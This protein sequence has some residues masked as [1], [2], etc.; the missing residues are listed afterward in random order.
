MTFKDCEISGMLNTYG[1]AVFENCTFKSAKNQYSLHIY[2]GNNFMLTN[3]HFYG[4]DKNVYVYQETVDCEK[5]VTFNNCDFHMTAA[6]GTKSAVM[7]NSAAYV[8]SYK[9]NLVMNSCTVEG[10]N[11]TAA[12]N[13]TG[14]TNY[15]GLYGLKHNPRI[16]TGTVTIDG[17]VVYSN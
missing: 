14:K 16:V 2:G 7:L 12:D 9:Y 15:Q 1:D 10:A 17:N 4:V 5:N 6:S 8:S 11:A 13:E 3:C